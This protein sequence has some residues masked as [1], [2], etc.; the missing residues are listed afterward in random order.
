[1]NDFITNHILEFIS[2]IALYGILFYAKSMYE[3]IKDTDKALKNHRDRI[4]LL[5]KGS[6]DTYKAIN[7]IN[8]KLNSCATKD[9]LRNFAKDIKDEI[10]RTRT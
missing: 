3:A 9:E 8:I 10:K 6:E 2:S 1:M 5:E 4:I 7:N